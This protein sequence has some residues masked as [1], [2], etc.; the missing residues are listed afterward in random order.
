MK[1][2]VDHKSEIFAVSVSMIREY[3]KTDR[4]TRIGTTFALTQN[5]N[6]FLEKSQSNNDVNGA[7][8]I[9]LWTCL[10]TFD[11]YILLILLLLTRV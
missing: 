5:A 9:K 8:K 4:T 1:A 2:I 3:E 10:P 7:K 11:F 6:K